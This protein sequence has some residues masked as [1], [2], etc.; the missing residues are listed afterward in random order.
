MFNAIAEA[1]DLEEISNL[2]EK[3]NRKAN[4]PIFTSNDLR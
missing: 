1:D 2:A 3:L 4:P